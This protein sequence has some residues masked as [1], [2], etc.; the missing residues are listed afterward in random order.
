MK[1]KQFQSITCLM[2]PHSF[3]VQLLTV[4]LLML[5]LSKQAMAEMDLQRWPVIQEAFFSKRPIEDAPFMKLSA[6]R[7]AENG[8]QVPI[9]ISISQRQLPAKQIKAIYLLIDA[10]PIPLAANYFPHNIAQDFKLATR[11]RLETDSFVRAVLE[12]G[13]GKLFLTSVEV[14]AGGGC[15][16][17]VNDKNEDE[18]RASAGKIKLNLEVPTRIGQSN[19]VTFIIK[20]PMRTGLQ[21]DMVTKKIVPAFY[22][23]RAKFL[24]DGQP[25]I[26]VDFGVGTSEDPYLRF[27]F[28]PNGP[29]MMEVSASDNEGK[30]FGA[31]MTLSGGAQQD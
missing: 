27:N 6:P 14:H 9:E 13:D 12:T 28:V 1:T 2:E 24:Y 26:D 22:I 23:Q 20:H 15:A 5:V 17:T 16:G 3:I 4:S 18:I 25:L 29:G 10:N 19:Q 11:V 21:K 30:T 8:A 7:G 31:Q